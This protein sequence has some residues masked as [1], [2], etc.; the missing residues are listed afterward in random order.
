MRN[1]WKYLDNNFL[2]GIIF[3]LLA[4]CTNQ[5]TEHITVNSME[6]ELDK[7][8]SLLRDAD[9]TYSIAETLDAAYYTGIG[10]PA[11]PFISPAED[12][13]TLSKTVKEEKVATNLAGFYALDA[14]LNYLADQTK[15]LPVYWLR[16]IAGNAIDSN[17]NLLLNRF[18]NATWKA[19]QPFRGLER[20]TRSTFV[21]ASHLPAEEIKK[22]EVQIRNA[23]KKLLISMQQVADSSMAAQMQLLRSLL[24]DEV[25]AVEMAAWLDSCYYAGQQKAPPP[26]LT[27]ADDTATIKKPAKDIKIAT[28]CAGFYALEC[29]LNYLVTTRQVLPSIILKSLVDRTISE[30]DK[31][32]FARFANATWKAGQPF[33]ELARIKRDIFTPFY[34][35][36]KADIE[37]DMVQVT[38]AA[39]KLLKEL[40][41]P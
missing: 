30:E 5:Q 9:F 7:I 32:I 23:A 10:Q 38:A 11:P 3:A 31:M 25:F 37:K 12:S 17:T 36:S 24:Q 41:T 34:F 19:G 33:Q 16:K 6:Q 8:D 14:G 13:A 4:S 20:I 28:N 1:S 27:K 15:E 21:V 22:D 2:F 18:A 35:L 40:H 39:E 26:F 29:G